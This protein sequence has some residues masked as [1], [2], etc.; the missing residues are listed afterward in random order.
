MPE[1]N[2]FD[3]VEAWYLYLSDNHSGQFSPEYKRLCAILEYFR[4]SPLLRYE[5]LS[6]NAREIYDQLEV[7]NG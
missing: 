6:D 5:T 7:R 1:F 4:P 2:R 3:I